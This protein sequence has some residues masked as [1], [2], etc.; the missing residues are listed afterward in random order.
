V[1]KYQFACEQCDREW[2]EWLGIKEPLPESCPHCKHGRPFKLMSKFV[3]MRKREQEKKT[4]KQN[5][6]DH[7]E[8]NRTILRQIKEE[9]KK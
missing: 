2:W 9:A 8:D 7:I 3:T 1:P 6:I 5:V 4:A